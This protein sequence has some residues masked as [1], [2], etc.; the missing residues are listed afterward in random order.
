MEEG[1]AGA[2]MRLI[3]VEDCSLNIKVD[4]ILLLNIF[5]FHYFIN[6]KPYLCVV[7]HV[8]ATLAL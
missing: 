1:R 3:R 7:I 6:I 2:N 8:C 4:I 5:T